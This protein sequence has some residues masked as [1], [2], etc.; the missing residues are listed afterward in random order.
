MQN[1]FPNIPFP[2]AP[3]S[4]VSLADLGK[5]IITQVS[6][7][8]KL[9]IYRNMWWQN[10]YRIPACDAE[11]V[12]TYINEQFSQLEG[13]RIQYQP[14]EYSWLIEYGTLPIELTTE[15]YKA[16]R[17]IS[18]YKCCASYAADTVNERLLNSVLEARERGDITTKEMNEWIKENMPADDNLRRK[19]WA[20]VRITLQYDVQTDEI[21]FEIM[22]NVS[23][24]SCTNTFIYF[25]NFLEKILLAAEINWSKRKNYIQLAEGTEFVLPEDHI[26]YYL[27]NEWIC[28]DVCSYL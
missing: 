16:Q 22:N 17:L 2:I 11:W 4:N 14:E 28:R 18:H 8:V 20:K 9:P 6:P 12:K 15:D 25:K 24:M 27:L 19:K 7:I 13:V 5:R 10:V 21:V 1:L 26:A 3:I 23:R